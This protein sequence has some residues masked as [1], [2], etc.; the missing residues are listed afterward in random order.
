MMSSRLFLMYGALLLVMGSAVGA[1][2]GKDLPDPSDQALPSIDRM[3]ALVERMRIEQSSFKTLQAAFV[4]H[5][6]S[7]MLLEAEVARGAFYYRSPDFVRWEYFEPTPKVIVIDGGTLVTWYKDLGTAERLHVG[8]HS[9]RILKYMGASGS[10]ETLL[11]YFELRVRWPESTGPGAPYRLKLDPRYE[12]VAKRLE[13]IEVEVDPE[14]FMPVRLH[15]AEPNGDV[16]EYLFSDVVINEDLPQ[17]RQELV[18]PADVE[19]RERAQP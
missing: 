15:Y 2:A 7:E 3:A 10:L 4:Q 14:R 16:T 17:D 8:R 18:L 11:E 1:R 19:V 13:V 6:E 5:T 12:R 9:D